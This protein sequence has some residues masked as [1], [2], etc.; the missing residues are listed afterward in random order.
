MAGLA[1][2]IFDHPTQKI[3]DQLLIFVNLYLG[4]MSCYNCESE[5][6]SIYASL[7]NHVLGV[8]ECSAC[9]RTCVLGALNALAYLVWLRAHV[10]SMLACF[11]SL[12]AHMSYM[13]AVL[14]YVTCLGVCMLVI[15]VCPIFF[16]V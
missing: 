3:F 13:L 4:F 7:L 8:L 11:M 1:T 5:C 2:P 12:R 15:L 6:E 10:L 14:K 16:Y 9:L